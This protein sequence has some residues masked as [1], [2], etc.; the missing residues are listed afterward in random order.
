MREDLVVHNYGEEAAFCGV[1]LE[2][3]SD[4]ADLFEVK[5]GRVA[6]VGTVTCE[7]HGS[8]MEFTYTR[9]T[10]RRGLRVHF[11]EVP[12]FAGSA[13]FERLVPAHGSW[14]LCVQ[15]TPFIDNTEITPRYRCGQP[16]ERAAPS[17]RLE[18][19][20]RNLP[21]LE[22]DHDDLRH[23][24]NR[25]T[26]DLA[27]L[28]LFD[29]EWPDR[30][31]VA[32]GAPWFMTVF[33][34]DSLITS[35]MCTLVDSEL[36]LGTLQTLALYQG[37]E[38][39]PLTEEEPG[40]ILHEMRFG[41]TARLSLG[42]GSI[43]YGS[44]D[45][46]PLFVM[47]VGELDRW[48]NHP[49]E[50]AAL[51]PA[52]DRALTWMDTFGDRDGDGYLEY[53]RTSDRGLANQGWKDSWD[54]VHL[55]DGTLA[56]TPIALC[57][58]QGY[59]YGALVARAEIARR[60]GDDTLAD[61]LEARAVELKI[62]FNHDFWLE[63]RGWL[64]IG[65]DRDKR[66]IDSLTSNM[67]HCLWTGI[68]NEEHAAVVAKRLLSPEMFSGWGIRTLATSMHRYNPV[69]YHNGSV[70]PHDNALC[71]AGLIRY[72]FAEEAHQV[73]RGIIDAG[74][75]F[76]HRLPEL[77]GGFSNAEFGFPVA[78]PTSCSPQAWAAAVPLLFLRSLLRLEPDHDRLYVAPVIP[79]WLE[80]FSIDGIP[81]RGGRL[82]L[83]V[84]GTKV[85]WDHAPD[86]LEVI[87]E[88][89]YGPNGERNRLL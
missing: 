51:L 63:D 69:S 48:G 52:A 81:V 12:R 47:L 71:A 50:M 10:F 65:L 1:E 86:R 19:W 5:E 24:V 45:A 72:G 70:W 26:E 31:V 84:S 75:Y 74:T 73:M 20:R 44:I 7:Q 13:S 33:G 67:G 77:F 30:S 66:P 27:A 40:R 57:E 68:L 8:S 39:D 16:V 89:L 14:S 42:G 6:K 43:Y 17:T 23:L 62:R 15:F 11:S 21:K 9:G 36:P 55:V 78:Y 32:A 82:A 28:R 61:T 56:A 22:T 3:A 38:V 37:T 18:T 88:P 87:H 58:V 4:F 34:R 79:D 2:L 60:R 54:S 35:W 41:E 59:R 49:E 53:Q 76:G 46:T 83:S 25:S 80:G 29:P 85:E 64:A